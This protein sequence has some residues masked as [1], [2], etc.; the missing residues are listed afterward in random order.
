MGWEYVSSSQP[1]QIDIGDE[2]V[3]AL[4]CASSHCCAIID[5]THSMP[6]ATEEIKLKCWG[7]NDHN[8]LGYGDTTNRWLDDPEAMGSN[9]P[10]VNFGSPNVSPGANMAGGLIT[11]L[12]YATAVNI[13]CTQCT[14]DAYKTPLSNTDACIVCNEFSVH[15]NITDPCR[16]RLGYVSPDPA[17]GDCGPC[18]EYTFVDESNPTQCRPCRPHSSV[19][20]GGTWCPCL[21]EYFENVTAGASQLD[22]RCTLREHIQ[23]VSVS[24]TAPV[25][26]TVA[27]VD[28][29]PSGVPFTVTLQSNAEPHLVITFSHIENTSLIITQRDGLQLN[30][31]YTLTVN[32]TVTTYGQLWE[33]SATTQTA[34]VLDF[35]PPPA[36]VAVCDVRDEHSAMCIGP[37][38]LN[39]LRVHWAAP[40][41]Y[42]Y[43][44]QNAADG[45]RE[46]PVEYRLQWQQTTGEGDTH[47]LFLTQRVAVIRNLLPEVVYI[48]RVSA[49]SRFGHNSSIAATSQHVPSVPHPLQFSQLL[50]LTT[51]VDGN[52]PT[53]HLRAVYPVASWQHEMFPL[54]HYIVQVSTTNFNTTLIND[55]VPVT[56]D[57]LTL[58]WNSSAYN[59]TL[60]KYF[61]VRVAAV[62]V[63]SARVGR[64]GEFATTPGILCAV[65][66]CTTNAVLGETCDA[67]FR[68]HC[69]CSPGYGSPAFAVNSILHKNSDYSGKLFWFHNEYAFNVPDIDPG[70]SV[71]LYRAGM[72]MGEF[73]VN[74]KWNAQ[75]Q[76]VADETDTT[77][78]QY[79][80]ITPYSSANNGDWQIADAL[81]VINP[82]RYGI[83]RCTMCSPGSQSDAPS[84]ACKPCALDHYSATHMQAACV[85]C[86]TGQD[87]GGRI[88]S[89]SSAQCQCKSGHIV[90]NHSCS[91]CPVDTFKSTNNTCLACPP[92]SSTNGTVANDACLCDAGFYADSLDK[93]SPCPV[94]TFKLITGDAACTSCPVNSDTNATLGYTSQCLCQAGWSPFD[95]RSAEKA[96]NNQSTAE[97]HCY[98]CLSLPQYAAYTAYNKTCG[99]D[100]VEGH[101]FV[102][103]VTHCFC[104]PL[105]S[106]TQRVEHGS[107][108]HKCVQDTGRLDGACVECPLSFYL[109]A[110]TCLECPHKTQV[111]NGGAY[112]TN[113]S[114]LNDCTMFKC[115]RKEDNTKNYFKDGLTCTPC[116]TDALGTGLYQEDGVCSLVDCAVGYSRQVARGCVACPEPINGVFTSPNTCLSECLDN[117]VHN[118]ADSKP[119]EC[120]ACPFGKFRHAR[121]KYC[122]HFSQLRRKQVFSENYSLHLMICSAVSLVVAVLTVFKN[123]R[124]RHHVVEFFSKVLAEIENNDPDTE[125]VEPFTDTHNDKHVA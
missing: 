72:S 113:S 30:T 92:H 123:Q 120:T 114:R 89:I 77:S 37:Q 14:P 103:N 125:E 34:R 60:G 65:D 15:D 59:L 111:L 57:N 6:S 62:D 115:T 54:V 83:D 50:K 31:L 79:A 87:T 4:A 76:F 36:S 98:Q 8:Q 18:P 25:T 105:A 43:H 84:Q 28:S 81:Y 22:D 55:T 118:D 27:W 100:C 2:S 119:A 74:V 11:D 91:T 109:S 38:E 86:D 93:C 10:F 61:Y 45:P 7:E 51:D 23:H 48:V 66:D 9:L 63:L 26:W 67:D 52:Q 107:C 117:Y 95:Q 32:S 97:K 42:G 94:D 46:L 78:N 102:K 20:P 24:E 75:S 69:S 99:W 49:D 70:V 56:A 41:H 122:T 64:V 5:K 17:Q 106:N 73:V 58:T 33:T 3:L 104:L 88:G 35:C 44:D 39:A 108:L 85:S 19:R 68:R 124:H 110:E 47:E 71:D 53:L 82:E 80:S 112:V 96:E 16:C 12:K 90:L 40:E 121:E 13:E 101:G 116:V 1:I 29:I 21:A